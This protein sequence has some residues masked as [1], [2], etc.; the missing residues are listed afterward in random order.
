M[1]L[2]DLKGAVVEIFHRTL[3]TIDVE[4]VVLSALHVNGDVLSIAKDTNDQ[5]DIDLSHYDN[6]LLIGIGKASLGM[7]RAL[8]T[9]LGGRLTRGL[10]ATNAI[11]GA[12][13]DRPLPENVRV[14]LAGHPVPNEGSLEAA[15]TALELLREFD[16]KK[17]L[18]FFVITGGGSSQFELPVEPLTLSELQRIN[19]DLVTSGKVISEINAERRLISQVKGGRLAEAAPR[20]HQI[21]L[22]ISDVNTGDL[23]TIASGPTWPGPAG[24]LHRQLLDN[25]RVLDI[26]SGIARASGFEVE[27]AHDLVEGEI[28]EMLAEHFKRLNLLRD[29]HPDS[30]VCLISGGEVICPV[31]GTGRGGRNQ[32]F[33]MRV[34]P[35]LSREPEPQR[36][37]LSAGSDGVDGNSPAAGAVVDSLR[38]S[39]LDYESFLANS[40][41]FG[42]FETTGEA[43][44]T[45]PTG[46]NVRDI[47]IFASASRSSSRS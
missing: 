22:Y 5:S 3:A 6:I 7:A 8:A 28:D 13:T 14:I 23:A 33:V 37:V 26:A 47:R 30:R 32:E 9:L 2:R 25:R 24:S 35:E 46:N 10:V 38:E 41:S 27:V 34:L 43:L 42:Y 17:T 11:T 39:S 15:R 16:C 19:H 44:T 29:R 1:E 31:R 45:G 21:S 4:R 18:V 40:D 36:V 12:I 20:S